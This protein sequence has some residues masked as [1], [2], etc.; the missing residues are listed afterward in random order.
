M[1]TV[2]RTFT[3]KE[4][5]RLTLLPASGCGPTLIQSEA[6]EVDKS[7]CKHM[8]HNPCYFHLEWNI[9]TPSGVVIVL[10]VGPHSEVFVYRDPI[11]HR[12]NWIEHKGDG[13]DL[14]NFLELFSGITYLCF[15][16]FLSSISF[17]RRELYL[18]ITCL[19]AFFYLTH[20]HTQKHGLLH[21]HTHTE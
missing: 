5:G 21:T 13:A 16:R 15:C 6:N 7:K 12:S 4:G 2:W 17:K 3:C 8:S 20:I 10:T 14:V 9:T 18:S 19:H 11:A 1:S